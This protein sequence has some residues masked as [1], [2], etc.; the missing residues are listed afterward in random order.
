[1]KILLNILFEKLHRYIYDYYLQ[2]TNEDW[3]KYTPYKQ[4]NVNNKFEKYNKHF[5]WLYQFLEPYFEGWRFSLR[6]NFP[7]NKK[8]FRYEPKSFK[9]LS[10]EINKLNWWNKRR[11]L[12]LNNINK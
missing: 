12:K 1:M 5:Y 4:A 11:Y 9:F 10:Y 2:S 7:K 3:G 8:Y 6:L